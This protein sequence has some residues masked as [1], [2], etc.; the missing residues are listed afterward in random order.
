MKLTKI[1]TRSLNCKYIGCCL[2]E[3][4][5]DVKFRRQKQFIYYTPNLSK[6]FS[7]HLISES[8]TYITVFLLRIFRVYILV[9]YYSI[10]VYC[11]QD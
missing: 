3:W 5:D 8:I 7:G 6:F 4:E 9:S 1:N 2:S 10:S 11:I